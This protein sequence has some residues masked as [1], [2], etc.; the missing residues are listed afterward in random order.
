MYR[1]QRVEALSDGIFAIVMTLLVLDLKVPADVPHG[2][3]WQVLLQDPDAWLSFAIT[4]GISARYWMLQHR[5]FEV[6]KDVPHKALIL[7][8]VFLG[9]VAVL[10]FSTA[11][12]GRHASEP[13]AILIYTLNQTAI[14]MAL[15]LKLEYVRWK[16]HART[17]LELRQLRYRLWSLTGAMAVSAILSTLVPLKW[18]VILPVIGLM[19]R[20]WVFPE[21]KMERAP[22]E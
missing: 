18:M 14:G 17:T 4:F 20:R 7:T 8:F 15:I 12:I 1:K 10:P 21:P 3:L 22:A 5:V 11:L 6:M 16:E 13:V 2:Q 9:L 19:L